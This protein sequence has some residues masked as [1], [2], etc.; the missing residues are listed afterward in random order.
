M[1]W[2][3]LC[4]SV[5]YIVLGCLL[6]FTPMLEEV[7]DMYRSAIGGVL[8]GYGVLRGGLWLRRWRTGNDQV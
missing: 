5:A 6:L 7:I 2:F 8:I 4:M 3:S 1:K